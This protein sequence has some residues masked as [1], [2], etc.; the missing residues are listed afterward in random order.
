MRDWRALACVGPLA[1]KLSSVRALLTM[2]DQRRGRWRMA[3][4]EKDDLVLK[5]VHERLRAARRHDHRLHC[6][7]EAER[8]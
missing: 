3:Y 7:L 1:R 5:K 4:D 8:K 6:L 2:N